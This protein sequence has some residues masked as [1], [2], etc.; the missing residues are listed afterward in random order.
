V[1][2][3]GHLFLLHPELAAA[4]GVPCARS[5]DEGVA[6]ARRLLGTTEQSTW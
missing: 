4:L 5:A 1:F 2:V 6:I 3:G